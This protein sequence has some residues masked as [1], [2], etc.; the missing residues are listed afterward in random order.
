MSRVVYSLCKL[1]CFMGWIDE[2]C[3][4][5]SRDV[6]NY[7]LENNLLNRRRIVRE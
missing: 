5:I 2:N 4:L 7:S 3:R 6:A 1:K